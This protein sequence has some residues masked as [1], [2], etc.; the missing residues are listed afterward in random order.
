MKHNR[1]FEWIEVFTAEIEA[2]GFPK[3]EEV[4]LFKED[5]IRRF[6]KVTK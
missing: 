3:V 4:S 5:R 2:A 6:P 1:A